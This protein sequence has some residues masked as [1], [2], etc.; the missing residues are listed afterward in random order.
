MTSSPSSRTARL[1]IRRNLQTASRAIDVLEQKSHA[2]ASEH[3]RLRQH[4]EET[5]RRWEEAHREAE[6]WYVRACVV[7]E[8][9]QTALA[10]AVLGDRPA[11]VRVTWRSVMGVTY[12][13]GA[14]LDVARGPAIGEVARSAALGEAASAHG[15]AAAAGLDH[16]A[17]CRALELVERE[18]AITRRRLRALEHRWVP[19]LRV[20]LRDVELALAAQEQDDAVRSRW[21]V[22]RTGAAR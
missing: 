18:L 7:G 9:P 19:R 15:R 20:G 3:R 10:E 21:A 8:E 4:V 6:T 2:L 16:A 11:Q 12:P 22:S 14:A 13:T 1:R 5:R 17:A